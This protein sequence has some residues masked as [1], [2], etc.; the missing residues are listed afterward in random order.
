MRG[1]FGRFVPPVQ[2]PDNVFD[3]DNGAVHHHSEIQCAEGEKVGGNFAQIEPDRSEHQGKRDR[4]GHDHGGANVAEEQQQDDGNQDHSLAEVVQHGVQGEVQQ[5][6]AV[7]HGNDLHA[8]GQDAVVELVHFLVNRV[9][10]WA[11]PPR[12]SA[13]AR[14]PE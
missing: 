6:A 7:Q 2:V 1:S 8:F 14:C 9:R 3:H 11:L 13:S 5:I 10:A 4:Q 12:L